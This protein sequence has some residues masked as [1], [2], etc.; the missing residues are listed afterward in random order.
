M[1]VW[2]GK[3]LKENEL[4]KPAKVIVGVA[5]VV[6]IAFAMKAAARNVA[7]E[8]VV[9]PWVLGIV[10]IGFI[11]FLVPKLTVIREKRRVSFGTGLMTNP[12]ANFYRLG[13]F[14]M[15]LGLLLAFA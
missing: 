5:I 13:Y 4:S 14:L 7:D 6:V 2:D 11:C 9:R 15:G 1:T 3:L 8:V 10:L 12:Q